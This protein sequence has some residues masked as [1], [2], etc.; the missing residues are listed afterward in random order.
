MER[1]DILNEA[2]R[3]IDPELID[4]IKRAQIKAIRRL[5][6]MLDSGDTD[7][8]LS[9]AANLLDIDIVAFICPRD[10]AKKP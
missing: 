2:Q 4:V 7:E 6:D 1:H 10:E 5:E 9:A 8:V 3:A